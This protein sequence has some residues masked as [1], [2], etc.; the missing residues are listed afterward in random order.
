MQTALQVQLR[1]CLV[2]QIEPLAVALPRRHRDGECLRGQ[3]RKT[4]AI[5]Y[6]GHRP[7]DFSPL[8]VEDQDLP[9]RLV[10]SDNEGAARRGLSLLADADATQVETRGKSEGD[11]IANG[12]RRRSYKGQTHLAQPTSITIVQHRRAQ[13]DPTLLNQIQPRDRS[14]DLIDQAIVGQAGADQHRCR[15]LIDSGISHIVEHDLVAPSRLICIQGQDHGTSRRFGTLARIDPA[16]CRSG[17]I[18]A[19]SGDPVAGRKIQGDLIPRRQVANRVE[20]QGHLAALTDAGPLQARRLHADCTGHRVVATDDSFQQDNRRNARGQTVGNDQVCNVDAQDVGRAHG[21]VQVGD[22]QIVPQSI[23]WQCILDTQRQ[24]DAAARIVARSGQD[25]S[26]RRIDHAIAIQVKHYIDIAQFVGEQPAEDGFDFNRCHKH[27]LTLRLKRHRIEDQI[28]AANPRQPRQRIVGHQRVGGADG[29]DA[30]SR[31]N[32]T[33]GR[34]QRPA[35]GLEPDHI[36]S[37]Q[38]ELVP[39]RDTATGRCRRARCRN[40]AADHLTGIFDRHGLDR[41]LDLVVPID[42]SRGVLGRDEHRIGGKI[43]PGV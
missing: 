2:G 27:L 33:P 14:V 6:Q 1:R 17:R 35:G 5:E 18:Q 13:P 28:A 38:A 21:V 16:R 10:F 11:L 12:Q 25:R 26:V 30:G 23:G 9:L 39:G 32:V 20:D 43:S 40:Q 22:D 34:E 15:P 41:K 19:R 31:S 42:Q 8:H 29:Q 4:H 3:H 24:F 36:G 7:R 37:G